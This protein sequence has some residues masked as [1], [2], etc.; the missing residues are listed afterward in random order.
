MP[1]YNWSKGWDT[2]VNPVI[3]NPRLLPARTKRRKGGQ[4]SSRIT[5]S[6]E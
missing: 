1:S 3:L 6:T 4:G 5:S 2:N